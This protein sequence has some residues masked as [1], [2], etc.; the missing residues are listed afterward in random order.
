MLA[1]TARL[2]PWS[3]KAPISTP[4]QTLEVKEVM[5]TKA[6][7]LEVAVVKVDTVIKVAQV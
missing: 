6:Q 7:A 4:E 2:N 3:I 5:V 1:A